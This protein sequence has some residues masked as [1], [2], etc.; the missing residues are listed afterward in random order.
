M[1][2][3]ITLAPAAKKR[4]GRP[5]NVKPAQPVE[6]VGI[7]QQPT[8]ADSYV[9]MIYS[10]P[11]LFKKIFALFKLYNA[12]TVLITFAAAEISFAAVDW[13][14]KTRI[15][16]S[17]DCRKLNL[18]YA[19]EVIKIAVKREIMDKILGQVDKNH[20]KITFMLRENYRSV[21]HISVHDSQ[22]NNIDYYTVDLIQR[23]AD[24]EHEYPHEDYPLS[25]VFDA[26]HFKKKIADIG[27]LSDYLIIQKNGVEP[28]QLTFDGE[29]KI[30]YS[31]IYINPE[32]IKLVSRV[33]ADDILSVSVMVKYIA[34]IAS[35][36][37][38]ETI[39]IFVDKFKKIVFAAESDGK[40]DIPDSAVCKVRVYSEIK[41]YRAPEDKK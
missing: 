4:P 38:G 30:D 25:F 8:A 13:Y 10:N 14:K 16:F 32:K 1:S 5:P 17:I 23:T 11:K 29:K 9:E 24:L 26:K 36:I 2:E 31:G 15:F 21:M 34:P 28:L 37:F 7:V 35:S 41:D 6:M 20:F 27:H 40:K 3:K 12:E 33:A 19:R 22:Y 18:Y 39:Q